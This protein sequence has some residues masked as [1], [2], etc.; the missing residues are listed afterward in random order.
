MSWL[1]SQALVA[2]YSAATS[3]DGAPSAPLSV[4][5][6]PHRFWRNGKTM[7]PSQLS[8][9]GLTCAVLTEDHGEALLMW[10]RG[11]F[12][13]PTY[14]SAGTPPAWTVKQADCGWSLSLIHI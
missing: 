6:T 13:A 3:S 9:F 12:P 11:D 14:P 1:F 10:F 2:E 4:M 5:P 8:L 7:K